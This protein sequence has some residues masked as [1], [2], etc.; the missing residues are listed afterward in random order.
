MLDRT[1][2]REPP[3]SGDIFHRQCRD[4]SRRQRGHHRSKH[5]PATHAATLKFDPP[6]VLAPRHS[7]HAMP[8]S[9]R[10]SERT[11]ERERQFL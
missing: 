8:Q 2:R 6:A 10:R 3:R 9:H 5:L 7:E 1:Q 11:R 4:H